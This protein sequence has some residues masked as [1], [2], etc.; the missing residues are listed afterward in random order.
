MNRLSVK[1]RIT[2]WYVAAMIIISSVVMVAMSSVSKAVIENEISERLNRT[3]TMASRQLAGPDG[4]LRIFPRFRFY[5]QGVHMALYDSENNMVE[6]HIPYGIP[7]SKMTFQDN[8]MRNISY[9]G[10]YYKMYDKKLTLSD[11]T[12]MWVKGVVSLSDENRSANSMTKLN[13]L[14]TAILILVAAVGGYFIVS[15]AFVPVNKISST[16]KE[17]AESSDLRRRIDIGNGK[18]EISNLANIFDAMLDKLQTTFER[19]KQFT[20]DASHELRTPVAVV[21]SECE[22]MTE[23]AKTPDEYMESAQSIKRQAEKM[24]KLISE[25]LMISR[26]DKHTLATEF[27]NV[28]L[29]ELVGFVC[30]E[31]QEIQ[32]KDIQLTRDIGD[33]IEAYCDRFLIMRLVINLVSNAYQYTEDGG[34]ID[35]SLARDSDSVVLTVR[36]TGI[37]ISDDDIGHIW[38][39]FYQADPSRTA[40]D[41]GSMG[42]GLAMVREIAQLH[43]GKVDVTSIKGEGSEFIFTLPCIN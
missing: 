3:V 5:D 22:Y 30:D 36:D 20:S 7:D 38:E 18:D 17:I 31:Q 43:G 24:S 40:K 29:S 12:E 26:M 21:L 37:G 33:G 4:K 6:G 13:I 23:C 14:M 27:E 19:E 1:L 15:R 10:S 41:S 9:D 35:V 11:G 39:R 8:D 42:L 25:L 16:A 28:N 32:T 34:V 2:L